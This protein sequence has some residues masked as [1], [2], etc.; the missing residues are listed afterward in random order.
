MKYFELNEKGKESLSRLPFVLKRMAEY[1]MQ[2]LDS[3]FNGDCSE[4]SVTCTMGT[5]K[6]NAEGRYGRG[7]TMNYDEAGKMLGF[8]TTNRVGLKKL[9]DKNNIH[10]VTSINNMPCGFLRSEIMALCDKCNKDIADRERKRK[11]KEKRY[12]TKI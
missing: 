4:E 3:V 10:E 9:L 12:N 7:D 11:N 6:Q 2:S 1:L 8:G 5:L